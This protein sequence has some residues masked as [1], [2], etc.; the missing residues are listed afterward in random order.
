MHET[1]AKAFQNYSVVK[2][3]ASENYIIGNTTCPPPITKLPVLNKLLQTAIGIVC[4]YDKKKNTT[5]DIK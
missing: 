5:K 2:Y 4:M 3:S 1:N